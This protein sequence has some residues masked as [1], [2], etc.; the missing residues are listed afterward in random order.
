MSTN[1]RFFPGRNGSSNPFGSCNGTRLLVPNGWITGSGDVLASTLSKV[2]YRID[3]AGG[4]SGAPI[5]EPDR[6][7]STGCNGACALGIHAYGVGGGSTVNSGT[8]INA[9]VLAF[10]NAARAAAP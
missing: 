7:A 8:R 5:F 4:Q 3:T 9:S 1:V 2:F 10:L 6:F